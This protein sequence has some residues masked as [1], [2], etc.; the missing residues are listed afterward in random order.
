MQDVSVIGFILIGASSKR[1]ARTQSSCRPAA[2]DWY[3][4][5]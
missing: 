4:D 3:L 1:Y 2:E 5:T